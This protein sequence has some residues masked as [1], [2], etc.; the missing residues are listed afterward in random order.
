MLLSALTRRASLLFRSSEDIALAVYALA[1]PICLFLTIDLFPS[2]ERFPVR[3][4]V[5]CVSALL[6]LSIIVLNPRS[7][8]RYWYWLLASPFSKL[9]P[10]G[11]LWLLTMGFVHGFM[12]PQTEGLASGLLAL[13]LAPLGFFCWGCVANPFWKRLI[14]FSIIIGLLVENLYLSM[15]LYVQLSPNLTLLNADNLPRLF[16]NTRHGNSLAAAAAGVGILLVCREWITD[17]MPKK[18]WYLSGTRIA[19]SLILAA[20]FFNG[21]LTQGRGLFVAILSGILVALI[22][23]RLRLRGSIFPFLVLMLVSF[24]LGWLLYQGLLLGLGRDAN[25]GFDAMAQRASGGRLRLWQS[26]I[27]SFLATSPWFGHGLGIIPMDFLDPELGSVLHAHNLPLQ[28]LCDAGLLG[29]VFGGVICLFAFSQLRFLRIDEKFS[30]GIFLSVMGVYSIFAGLLNWPT[31][32]W[33]LS[34]FPGLLH[35]RTD[36]DQSSKYDFQIS[37]YAVGISMLF[38]AFFAQIVFVYSKRIAF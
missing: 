26:W 15:Y 3:W 8:Q 7:C 23:R 29:L 22:S 24:A 17:G 16:M 10:I 35:P 5:L 33:L 12:G 13:L 36:R 32:V 2:F 28:L 38:I 25:V 1:Y 27:D 20:A 4:Q 37:Q 14:C 18:A 6:S 19:G 21:W 34:C 30:F 11:L 9:I 31:G